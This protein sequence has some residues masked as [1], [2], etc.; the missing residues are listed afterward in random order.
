LSVVVRSGPFRTA[1]NGTLVAW[2]PRITSSVTHAR[3]TL[4]VEAEA[5]VEYSYG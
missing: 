5:Y 4:A 2:P 3:L 1:V